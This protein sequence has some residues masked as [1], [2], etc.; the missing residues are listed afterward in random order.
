[1]IFEGEEVLFNYGKAYWDRWGGDNELKSPQERQA[2]RGTGGDEG[3]CS[4][5]G[6]RMSRAGEGELISTEQPTARG[7]SSAEHAGVG[8]EGEE[9]G[10]ADDFAG[11]ERVVRREDGVRVEGWR[12]RGKRKADERVV[13]APD[14]GQKSRKMPKGG[15][16]GKWTSVAMDAYISRQRRYE[17]GEG[18]GVT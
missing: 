11:E 6:R 13:V 8:G 3:Q 12:A 4:G 14:A 10:A 17:R 15:I 1:M 16:A 5:D 7:G 2:T 9:N 18:G